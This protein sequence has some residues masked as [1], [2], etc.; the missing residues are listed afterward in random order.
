MLLHARSAFFF[1]EWGQ[2]GTWE[3]LGIFKE[4]CNTASQKVGWMSAL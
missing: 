4:L 1:E 3:W 2:K